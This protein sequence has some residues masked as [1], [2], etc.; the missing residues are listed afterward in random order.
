MLFPDERPSSQQQIEQIRHYLKLQL[1]YLFELQVVN[2]G[3]Q[4]YLVEQFKLVISPTLIKIHPE[5]QQIAGSNLIFQLH[6]WWSRQQH[7]VENLI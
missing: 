7:T 1:E 6:D 3:Q 2:V 4:P 5:T